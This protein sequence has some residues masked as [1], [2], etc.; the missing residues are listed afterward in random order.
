MW[1]S[2]EE[3][4][5][6]AIWQGWLHKEKQSNRMMTECLR[7][8]GLNKPFDGEHSIVRLVLSLYRNFDATEGDI[9]LLFH[10]WALV[11]MS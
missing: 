6:A 7:P 8:N 4:E 1:H 2:G 5:D 10:D 11:D 3:S 9:V